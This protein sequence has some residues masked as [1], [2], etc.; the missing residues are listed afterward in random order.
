MAL[1]AEAFA[2]VVDGLLGSSRNC[3][4]VCGATTA[5][6]VCC[7]VELAGLPGTNLNLGGFGAAGFCLVGCGLAGGLAVAVLVEGAAF[8][9]RSLW[10]SCAVA[11]MIRPWLLSID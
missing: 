9:T 5:G 4:G 10:H 8:T 1:D 3:G 2:R 6:G 7:L 11:M